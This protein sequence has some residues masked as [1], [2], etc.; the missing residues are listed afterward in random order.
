M[1]I[2]GSSRKLSNV[3]QQRGLFLQLA[4]VKNFFFVG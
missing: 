1:K 3:L 2:T 4:Q